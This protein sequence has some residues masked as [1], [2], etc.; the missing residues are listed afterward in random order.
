MNAA[1]CRHLSRRRRRF[2]CCACCGE[3][4]EVFPAGEHAEAESILASPDLVSPQEQDGDERRKNN[5][6]MK[7]SVCVS[8][9]QQFFFFFEI[10][11]SPAGRGD[12]SVQLADGF[13]ADKNY[14]KYAGAVHVAVNRLHRVQQHQHQPKT[15]QGKKHAPSLDFL[16]LS[17]LYFFFFLSRSWPQLIS[18]NPAEMSLD[19]EYTYY[20]VHAPWSCISSVLPLLQLYAETSLF[21][22][23]RP[24]IYFLAI[25]N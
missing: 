15:A 17:R 5:K 12:V 13:F 6:M 24:R 14:E 8:K 2:A 11:S 20:A 23:H 22:F 21:F 25:R 7:R 1:R 4:P 16:S 10:F 9:R 3:A 19:D 18:L